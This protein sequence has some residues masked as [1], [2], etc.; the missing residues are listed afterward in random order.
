MTV[1]RTFKSSVLAAWLFKNP[2]WKMTLDKRVT[3]AR[4]GDST[5]NINYLEIHQLKIKRGMIWARINIQLAN[6]KIVLS[7]IQNSKAE[8]I[9]QAINKQ[10]NQNLSEVLEVHG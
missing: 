4:V 9:A 3:L 8:I 7:G 10:I 5:R 6:E 2:K 1:K